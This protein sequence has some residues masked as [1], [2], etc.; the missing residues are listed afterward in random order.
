MKGLV[1][2]NSYYRDLPSYSL[3]LVVLFFSRKGLN[4]MP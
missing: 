1:E 3:D 2:V 4:L